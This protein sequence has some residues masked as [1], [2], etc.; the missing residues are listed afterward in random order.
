MISN[1][2]ELSLHLNELVHFNP[3]LVELTTLRKH[4]NYSNKTREN[5]AVQGGYLNDDLYVRGGH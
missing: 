3:R 1:S 5:V 4:L 2:L